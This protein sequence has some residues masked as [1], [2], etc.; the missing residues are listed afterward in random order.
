MA[1]RKFDF[2]KVLLAAGGGMAAGFVRDQLDKVEMFRKQQPIV[3]PLALA[4]VGAGINFF[5]NDKMEALGLGILGVAGAEIATTMANRKKGLYD[6]LTGELLDGLSSV[7]PSMQGITGRSRGLVRSAV[8]D[9]RRASAMNAGLSS[10]SAPSYQNYQN[11]GLG[12]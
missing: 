9:L 11:G 5:L 10:V 3:K 12:S 1:K 8:R 4:A 7:T 6:P 2:Q